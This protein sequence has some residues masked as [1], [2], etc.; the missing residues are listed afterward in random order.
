MAGRADG[1][2]SPTEPVTAGRQ[3]WKLRRRR[4]TQA[5]AGILSTISSSAW[6]FLGV[7]ALAYVVP[8]PDFA[9]VLRWALSDRRLGMRAAA[10]TVSGLL[11]HATAAALGVSALLATSAEA[12][13]LVKLL[14]ACYLVILGLGTLRSS[15]R[16]EADPDASGA[17]AS[18][19]GHPWRQAF[20][21]NVLNP[22]AALFFVALLPQFVPSDSGSSATLLL[23]GATVA[24]GA[25]WWPTIVL[26]ASRL[27]GL[28]RARRVRRALDALT[29]AGLVILG[30][31]LART[32][33]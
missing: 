7:L 27:S 14:G 25:V 32:P 12:F 24:F 3:A 11:V 31:R 23:A 29:G 15:L 2:S 6:S 26:I 13:T 30:V 1:V 4:E 21:T 33:H 19:A 9:V 8:G 28:P 5:R 16:R 18:G 20:L 10:G 17:P 22:K